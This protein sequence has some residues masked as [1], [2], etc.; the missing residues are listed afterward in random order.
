MSW[1]FTFYRWENWSERK[2]SSLLKI[3]QLVKL[4]CWEVFFLTVT[5]YCLVSL[6]DSLFHLVSFSL[7]WKPASTWGCMLPYPVTQWKATCTW[8]ESDQYSEERKGEKKTEGGNMNENISSWHCLN[9]LPWA[10]QF[11]N[12]RNSSRPAPPTPPLKTNLI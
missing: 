10:S 9:S 11:C 8:R 4:E 7:W 3:A 5:R 12:I 1:V 2:L 6:R